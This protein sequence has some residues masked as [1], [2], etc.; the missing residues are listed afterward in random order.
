MSHCNTLPI[1]THIRPLLAGLHLKSGQI[2]SAD[3]VIDASGK[4][5]NI[6]KWLESIGHRPPSTWSVNAGLKYAYRMYEMTEDADRDWLLAMCM[7]YPQGSRVGMMIPIE[8][9]KWQVWAVCEMCISLACLH[10]HRIH[11]CHIHD[12]NLLEHCMHANVA[13]PSPQHAR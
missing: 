12:K 13:V 9:N 3:L 10:T 5:S 11:C 1:R 7:D 2:L 6:S 8:T 4:A